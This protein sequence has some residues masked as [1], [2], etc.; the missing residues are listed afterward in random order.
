LA[1]QREQY[2]HALRRGEGFVKLPV[3]FVGVHK[4]SEDSFNLLHAAGIVTSNEALQ[5]L[6]AIRPCAKST[7]CDLLVSAV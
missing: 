1:D 5:N 3:G 4:A 7:S 2:I 6:E